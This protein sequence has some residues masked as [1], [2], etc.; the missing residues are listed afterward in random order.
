[1]VDTFVECDRLRVRGPVAGVLVFMLPRMGVLPRI[2]R[3][4]ALLSLWW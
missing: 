3:E 1:M 2:E 4:R